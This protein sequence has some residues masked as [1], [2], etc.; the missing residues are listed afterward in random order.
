MNREI[1]NNYI[2]NNQ[3]NNLTNYLSNYL[4]L[5]K[6]KLY[7]KFINNFQTNSITIDNSNEFVIILNNSIHDEIIVNNTKFEETLLI[8]DTSNILINTK[9]TYIDITYILIQ[10]V[11]NY[12]SKEIIESYFESDNIILI[13]DKNLID[14]KTCDLIKNFIDSSIHNK[15]YIK[16][17]INKSYNVKSYSLKLNKQ[18]NIVNSNIFLIK[19]YDEIIFD[20]IGKIIK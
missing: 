16:Y 1:L 6:E 18:H 2:K 11:T 7:I 19:K 8:N 10:N 20:I 12:N 13:N 5:H 9:L 3:I 17:D 4:N 14:D 15:N